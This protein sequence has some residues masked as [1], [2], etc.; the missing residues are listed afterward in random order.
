MLP[1]KGQLKKLLLG[2]GHFSWYGTALRDVSNISV[3]SND[4]RSRK[5]DWISDWASAQDIVARPWMH[6]RA[7]ISNAPEASEQ[8]L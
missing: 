1:Q 5:F 7:H 2:V 8:I 6:T 4:A 3:E